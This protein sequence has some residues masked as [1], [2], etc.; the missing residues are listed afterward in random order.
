MN[1]QFVFTGRMKAFLG[2]LIGIGALCLILTA[3]F[4]SHE[5]V[6][7]LTNLLH[8]SVF[9][10]G[11]SFAALFF[12]CVHTLAW[13]GWQTLFKRIPEAM[14]MFLPIGLILL[15]IVGV[16][17]AVGFKGTDLLYL[18]SDPAVLD[19]SDE[20]TYDVLIDGKSPLLNVTSY[21]MT[22]AVVLLWAFFA[23]IIRKLSINQD[24]DSSLREPNLKKTRFWAA[25]F[26]PIA[27]FSSAFAIWMWVMSVDPHWYSTLF[28][29][30]VSV[31]WWVAAIAMIMMLI[32]FLQSQ[33]YLQGFTKSHMHDLGKYIFGFSVFWTY[34]WFSQFM[35][36][37][38]GNNGEE[39]QYFFI[40]FEQF[41]PV[42][43]MNLIINF[44]LPFFI[45]MMNSS[46]RTFGTVGFVAGLVFFGHWLD[47]YQM[48]KP[49]VWYNYEHHQHSVHDAGG[50]GDADGHDTHDHHSDVY[51]PDGNKFGEGQAVLTF[52]Q[53][54]H[55]DQGHGEEGH[56]NEPHV[57]PA[58]TDSTHATPDS[59]AMMGATD[60]HDT[61]HTT[62]DHHGPEEHHAVAGEHS[63][64]AHG[65]EHGHH[66]HH[67]HEFAM[68]I[69]FPGFLEVGTMLGFLGLFLFV[70]FSVLSRASLYPENDP[71]LGESETHSVWPFSEGGHH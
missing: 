10:L 56:A 63:H 50:H 37:W 47:F 14:S 3:V 55:D 43:F 2:G 11:I 22:F 7:L 33:G 59:T 64:D 42:F 38:Y 65:D 68:G 28:A 39:T 69:H 44:A 52:F 35:L 62:D 45:L 61:P 49:G 21:F 57:D 40:R 6:R 29:W 24:K 17:V 20:S 9:F 48:I 26:L 58:H 27:G 30:Y 18:W 31:S 23:Y 51:R 41:K 36:I 19:A 8:N 66:G 46:K 70:T 60:G 16:L 32:I 25:I 12:I 13:G 54:P 4:D 5:N 34:L 67:E 1:N 71:F 53:E 15:L